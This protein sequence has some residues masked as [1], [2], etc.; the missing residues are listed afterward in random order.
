VLSSGLSPTPSHLDG[1]QRLAAV[2]LLDADVDIGVRGG[3]AGV[4][5]SGG[6][7]V[8]EGV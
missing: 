1:G 6:V 4:F 2:A 7:G 3:S 5:T 8:L